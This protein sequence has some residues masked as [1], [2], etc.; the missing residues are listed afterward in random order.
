MKRYNYSNEI[1]NVVKQFLTKDEWHYSFDEERG[2]FDFG[3][4]VRNKIQKIKYIIDIKEDDMVIYGVCPISA[5]SDDD[6]MMAQMAEFICRA[7]FGLNNGCFEFDFRDGEIRYKSF[8]DCDKA[9]PSIEVV[10]NSIYCTAEMYRRYADGIVSIIFMESSAKEA[11]DMCEK[12]ADEELRSML[13]EMGTNAGDGDVDDMIARLTERL[14]I[15]SE[16]D[17]TSETTSSE[18]ATEVYVDMFGKKKA[19]AA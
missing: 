14:G 13:T 5:D 2:I 8:I 11:I 17:V 19:E 7:N 4:R 15:T 18:E 9:L 12:S 16:E 3:L 6:K 10:R 1:A